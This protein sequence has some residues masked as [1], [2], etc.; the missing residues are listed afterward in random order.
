MD[1][2]KRRRAALGV[3][4]R[5]REPRLA[6][7]DPAVVAV[8]SDDRRYGRVGLFESGLESGVVE[9]QPASSKSD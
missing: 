3:V 1:D 8:E 4:E 7:R 9:A 5:G 2:E 6:T